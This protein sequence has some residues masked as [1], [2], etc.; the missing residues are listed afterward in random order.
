M[1]NRTIALTVI[2]PALLG[3]V[4]L[5]VLAGPVPVGAGPVPVGAGS[6]SLGAGSVSFRAGS[7]PVGAGPVSFRA[8]SNH[9][10]ADTALPMKLLYVV[11]GSQNYLIPYIVRKL[12]NL[13]LPDSDIHLY[14]TVDGPDILTETNSVKATLNQDMRAAFASNM[15]PEFNAAPDTTKIKLSAILRQYQSVLAIK[16]TTLQDLVEIQF[17]LYDVSGDG[18]VIQYRNSSSVFIDP[19]SEHYQADL[20]RCIDQVFQRANKK[21]GVNLIANRTKVDSTYYLTSGDTLQFQPLIEDESAEAD[22]IYF[23]TQDSLQ[24]PQLPIEPAKKDQFLTHLHPGIY[25]LYFKVSNGINYSQT[26]TIRLNVYSRPHLKIM[27]PNQG[28]LLRPLSDRLVIQEYL[29]GARQLDNSSAYEATYD[30]ARFNRPAPELLVEI[31]DQKN[32]VYASKT[33]PFNYSL[34]DSTRS[35]RDTSRSARD[36]TRPPLLTRDSTR[37][38]LFTRDSTRS[39]LLTRDSTRPIRP[40]HDTLRFTVADI[41]GDVDYTETPIKPVRGNK[42]TISFV[43]RNTAKESNEVKNELRVYQHRPLSLLYDVMIFPSDKNGLYHSWINAGAG[44]DLRLNK[45]LS[46]VAIVGTDLAQAS[47]KH[48]YI[49][50]IANFGPIATLPHPFNK[51]EGGP[52]LLINHDDG[53]QSTG[54]KISYTFYSGSQT[55]LKIGGSF[56]NLDHVNFYALHFTGDIF[57]NH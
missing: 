34:R 1:D 11:E 40:K 19:R 7:N 6:V 13:R 50:L 10:R 35:V 29:F 37:S 48:F 27:K 9:I 31:T 33:F 47:F 18:F 43:A 57:F 39:P 30:S 26:E 49:D 56:Y 41:V 25:Y 8:R 5:T 38:P 15:V 21:P 28:S 44:L 12:R 51:L 16:D 24:R 20:T 22:R 32:T 17:T 45:F 36:S 23:W 54:F 42:Y 52:A 55:N 2:I 4:N 3:L 14:R 53:T 46:A